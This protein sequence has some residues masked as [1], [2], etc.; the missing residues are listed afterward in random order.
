MSCVDVLSSFTPSIL[1][2]MFSSF[3]FCYLYCLFYYYYLYNFA[4]LSESSLYR[5]P[6]VMLSRIMLVGTYRVLSTWLVC[7]LLMC[8]FCFSVYF[9][10]CVYYCLHIY[11]VTFYIFSIYV[12]LLF[13]LSLLS[14][15]FV[16]I[17]F[18]CVI[19]CFIYCISCL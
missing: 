19:V 15:L 8:I 1:Y 10:F 7:S 13:C 17:S 11:M 14:F 18:R 16:G 3:Y 12:R 6:T 5:W 2:F 9:L 4:H